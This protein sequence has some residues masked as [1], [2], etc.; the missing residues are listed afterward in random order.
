MVRI[1]DVQGSRTPSAPDGETLAL[2][3]ELGRLYSEAA[4]G[5]G[6][7]TKLGLAVVCVAAALVLLSA[8]LF[9]TAWAGPLAPVIPVVAGLI[10][11]GGLSLRRRTRFRERFGALQERL[12]SRG[13]DAGRPAREGLG[14]YY[15]VQLVLLR[16]EYEYLLER[17]ARKAARLFEDSFGFTP[18]DPFE[19]GPL[20]VAPDTEG[21]ESL[22]ERWERRLA[23]RRARGME[24]PALGAR[25]DAAY[26]VFPREMT[27]PVELSMRRAYLGISHRLMVERYGHDPR[28]KLVLLPDG[29]RRRAE[30]DLR[31]YAALSRGQARGS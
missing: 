22:R 26:R 6:R 8:P 23:A 11:G 19:T 5:G 20:N 28:E 21:M 27:V 30:R 13:L 2:W 12:A 16:S 24:P 18:E 14:A 7:A 25:E 1:E 4:G 29:L 10:A 9:G 3:Y 31:E 17:G 15:D